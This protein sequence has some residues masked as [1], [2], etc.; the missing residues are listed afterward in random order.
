MNYR[1]LYHAGNFADV[2]KHT[3][4]VALIHSFL[5]KE[6]GFCYLDTHAGAGSYDLFSKEAQ[7]NKEFDGGIA[8]LFQEKNPPTFINDYLNCIKK[9][10]SESLRYYPG[11]P[12]IV[13]N[14]LRENDQMILTELQPKEYRALKK[15]F[16]ND[17]KVQVH[18]RDGYEGLN[19]FLPPKTRRGLILIDPPYE[20]PNEL[21]DLIVPL[22]N[23]V[24]RFETGVYAIW[25]PIKD[26]PPIE[27]FKRAVKAAIE[28]PLLIVELSL[29][30][31]TTAF[32]LN[33]C[34]MIIVN[35]PWQL[36][37]QLQEMLPW[38]WKVL[39]IHQQG[40]Y[41]IKLL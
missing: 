33:G 26:R 13:Q 8:K 9:M 10:N 11:S 24:K 4:L 12:L 34:G 2:F 27:R 3:I 35:P 41:Q 22:S 37:Q 36:D 29:Y 18:S 6:T 20:K 38:L 14:F 28:R 40:Q 32:Q 7:I 39:S 25:Y 19:A 15:I 17:I 31:E 23:T 5:K 16:L 1:H 30:P 21:N